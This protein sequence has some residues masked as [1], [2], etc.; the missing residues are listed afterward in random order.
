MDPR[1]LACKR[2]GCKVFRSRD[3]ARLA[4]RVAPSAQLAAIAICTGIIAGFPGRAAADSTAADEFPEPEQRLRTGFL[5]Y[6]A[7]LA[8]ELVASPGAI[9]PATLTSPCVL[10]SGGGLGLRVGYRFHAPWYVGAAYEFSK[11]DAHKAMHVA[12]LQQM[13]GEVRF[14][15][16]VRGTLVPFVTAG[17]G[18]VTYGSEFAVETLGGMAFLGAGL[19]IQLSRTSLFTIITSYRPILL[20]TW[21]DTTRAERPTGLLSMVGL[22]VALEQ[23]IPTYQAA[24]P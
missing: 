20:T 18:F 22:E 12:M 6:G 16:P 10:G 24:G 4:V 11:Q 14:Y 13:R 21:E 3:V 17:A 8:A 5:Q 2:Y 9:C 7:A 19:E 23:R 15:L 1:H